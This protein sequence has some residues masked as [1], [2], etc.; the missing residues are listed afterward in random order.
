MG[1]CGQSVQCSTYKINVLGFVQHSDYVLYGWKLLRVNFKCSCHTHTHIK[2]WLCEVMAVWV[3]FI[4][5]TILQYICISSNHTVYLSLNNMIY[6]LYLN[7]AR[8]QRRKKNNLLKAVNFLS[9]K[10]SERGREPMITRQL[11]LEI[12]EKSSQ[13]VHC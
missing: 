2:R 3:N 1:K 6:Q 12:P 11:D 7:I 4:M 13:F 8:K 10:S 9:L 5:V